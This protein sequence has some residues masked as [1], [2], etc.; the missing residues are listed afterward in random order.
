MFVALQE[1]V[2]NAI[3]DVQFHRNPAGNGDVFRGEDRARDPFGR[4]L[5]EVPKEDEEYSHREKKAES[6]PKL[7]P[8]LA[9]V[10]ERPAS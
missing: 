10:R 1:P 7:R 9:Q 4:D 6:Q 5:D 2:L 8:E 3:L